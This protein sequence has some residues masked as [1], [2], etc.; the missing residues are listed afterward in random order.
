MTRGGA[1]NEAAGQLRP[2]DTLRRI[3]EAIGRERIVSAGG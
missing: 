1:F 2:L 3:V